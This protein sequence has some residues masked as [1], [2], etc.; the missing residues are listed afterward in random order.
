[1]SRLVI[2]YNRK[3]NKRRTNERTKKQRY[4]LKHNNNN[5]RRTFC[6]APVGVIRC[7]S[8]K[9]TPR[10]YTLV[11][12]YV[13]SK[14]FTRRICKRNIH[15]VSCK[16]QRLY[17]YTRLKCADTRAGCEIERQTG[18]QAN[19]QGKLKRYVHLKAWWGQIKWLFLVIQV[20]AL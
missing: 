17:M 6:N 14:N 2:F 11:N 15:A 8:V 20:L 18:I 13:I 7:F 16:G 3:P 5:N 1:M 4:R 9:S 10:K 12:M 19:R